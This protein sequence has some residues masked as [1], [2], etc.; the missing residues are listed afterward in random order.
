M[1][2]V[3]PAIFQRGAGVHAL[4]DLYAPINPHP[5]T[6]F[7]RCKNIR[8]AHVLHIALFG[9]TGYHQAVEEG[10]RVAM[11]CRSTPMKS[12]HEMLHCRQFVRIRR[13]LMLAWWMH[14]QS[15]SH[16]VPRAVRTL[17]KRLPPTI[18]AWYPP[19]PMSNVFEDLEQIVCLWEPHK[20]Q[21]T[22]L[23]VKLEH[24]S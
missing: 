7:A 14:Q 20:R 9:G 17:D 12:L 2:E 8:N 4:P 3:V 22:G 16:A 21:L 15:C 18:R 11:D 5:G 6:D 10:S 24:F 19:R 1:D 23:D 13:R